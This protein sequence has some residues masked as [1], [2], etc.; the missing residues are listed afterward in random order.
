MKQ[1][2]ILIFLLIFIVILGS[3]FA[4]LCISGNKDK[5]NTKP[6]VP[7]E[8][9]KKK[10]EPVVIKKLQI[11]DKDSN[12]RPIAVMVNNIHVATP[13]QSGLQDA[14]LVY[15]MI[16]EGGITRL[17]AVFKDA[18]TARIGS[19]R[20]SR[21]YYL[22]YVMENDA[23][24]VHDGYSPFAKDD[25]SKFGINNLN[26]TGTWRE[27]DLPVDTEHTEFSSIEKITE[28]ATKRNYR[29]TSD[30]KTLLNYSVDE[31][32]LMNEEG[33]IKADNLE[34]KFSNYHTTKFTY[35]SEN[36][37]YLRGYNSKDHV[38]YIT[39]KQYT[40]KNIIVA[41]MN[42]SGIANDA[43][44]RQDLSNIGTGDGYYITDGY[45]IPIKWTK[46]SRESQT[47]YKKLNGEE[48]KVN[49]G[50]TH[51]ENA[52]LKSLTIKENSN[53]TE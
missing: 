53:V 21:H 17:M 41:L 33:A 18:D 26:A 19:I 36:M 30:K 38:D 16:V 34:V 3:T 32:S 39:K 14:Y 48:I 42:N 9:E 23:I 43:K 1:K 4:Y 25:I 50:N 12:S 24:Y 22:D 10:E 28:A 47:V 31:V 20:S 8:E 45:A 37:V 46:D 29:L 7:I 52:P 6:N 2:K 51:I 44:G 11:I 27:Y 35:D 5:N 49:D 15:E 40:A 13:Y